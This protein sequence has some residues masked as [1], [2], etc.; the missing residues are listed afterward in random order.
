MSDRFYHYLVV[1]AAMMSATLFFGSCDEKESSLG[2]ELQD[3]STLY[4]GITDSAYGTACTVF[5]DTLLTSGQSTVLIGCYSDPSFG[6]SEAVLYT[7]VSTGDDGDMT[8]DQNCIVDSAVLSFA[9]TSLFPDASKAYRDMHFEI[10]QL[11]ESVLKDSAYYASDVLP[12]TST[13][14]FDDVVRVVEGDTMVVSMRLNNNFLDMLS[15]HSFANAEEFID[16]F[17]GMR[18][19]VVNDGS[20]IMATVNL[21]ASSTRLTAF[22]T[23]VNNGDSINRTYD[24]SFGSKV[25]HF[26]HYTNVYCGALAQFNTNVND[27]IDGSRYLY[28][29]PMGGTNIKLSFDSFVRQFSEQHPL[30]IIHYAELI[31]PL[32]DIAPA[33]H[34][35]L[36]AALKCYADGSV[37]NITDMY[38]PYT[39]TGYDGT[40]DADK[41]CYRLRVTQY[42]QKMIKSGEDN[43]TLLVISG[44]RS[45]PE[46][47]IING[48][49]NTLT[50]D[51]PI[52]L[53]F[54]Y[55]E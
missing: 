31:L 34:P 24:F 21:A 5:D 37:A 14:F 33:T 41:G 30:A 29:S 36:I 20:P 42:L 15:N 23:Y 13:C 3:P 22:Y 49:D 44:R 35:E 32:A 46:H 12:T 27:S 6:N 53:R 50:S 40:F 52:R 17:K 47:T 43:G 9:I 26:S 16:A 10:Y 54:V 51:N 2:V 8:F 1:V 11:A 25:P 4:N 48:Y 7:Q 45:S 38:D 28:L 19:R 18:I 39:Y 55:S